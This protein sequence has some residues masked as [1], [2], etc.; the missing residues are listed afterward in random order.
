MKSVVVLKSILEDGLNLY[1]SQVSCTTH[2]IEDSSMSHNENQSRGRCNLICFPFLFFSLSRLSNKPCQLQSLEASAF[3]DT[4]SNIA[5]VFPLP[6]EAISRPVVRSKNSLFGII[7]VPALHCPFL[8]VLR[9]GLR[10][11]FQ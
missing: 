7:V 1:T 11:Q 8:P 10:A 2:F 6:C 9:S 4:A 3:H 5:F